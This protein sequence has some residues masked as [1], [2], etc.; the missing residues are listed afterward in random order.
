MAADD[1]AEGRNVISHT[2]YSQGT[3]DDRATSDAE[4]IF[5]ALSQLGQSTDATQR[6]SD[7]QRGIRLAEL[8][9]AQRNLVLL[10]GLE[11][12]QHPPG[13][14]GGRV[15]DGHRALKAFLQTLANS[16]GT[17]LCVVTTRYPLTDLNGWPAT[18]ETLSLP[19]LTEEAGADL[20]RR[21]I[22]KAKS[23]E[24]HSASLE[25]QGHALALNLLGTYVR[26][27]WKG[28]V[29]RCLK[30]GPWGSTPRRV[31]V[32]WKYADAQ[33]GDPAQRIMRAYELSFGEGSELAAL[34]ILGLFDRPATTRELEAVQRGDAIEGLTSPFAVKRR[35]PWPATI[36]RLQDAG[37][38]ARNDPN[39]PDTID[40]HP[41]VRDYFGVPDCATALPLP[42]K[43]V[44]VA[45]TNVSRP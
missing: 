26:D 13:Q 3:S 12:L 27:Q 33:K 1:C 14:F 18:V 17:A 20:L 43:R 41:L 25:F 36:R 23:E 35:N 31:E 6:Q 8:V 21:Y 29:A 30:L 16:R 34:R 37:L 5:N 38:V 7:Y 9:L 19:N 2:F 10:D 39:N 44:I 45:Y 32:D 11:P 4:F 22:P 28:D 42:G 24:L 40:T 15:K